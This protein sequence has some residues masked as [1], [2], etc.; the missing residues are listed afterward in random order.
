MS[1]DRLGN[2]FI[3]MKD[4]CYNPNSDCYRNYGGRG[5][6]I[7]EEWYTPHAHK[8]SRAFRKWALENGYKEGLTI[9]R[10]NVNKGYSPDNCK[11]IPRELQNN[12]K[13]NNRYLTYNGKTQTMTQW[14]R[15][16]NLS[17]ST[18]RYRLSRNK[19]IEKVFNQDKFKR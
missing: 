6:T 1:T 5:I 16:L 7:C 8:G 2:I 18:V 9:E 15:E 14:C 10:I 13:R 17:S 12:N 3:H 4:R 11:W 19:P